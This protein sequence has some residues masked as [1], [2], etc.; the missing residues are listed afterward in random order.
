MAKA[1]INKHI[2][3]A[4]DVVLTDLF[5]KDET[6]NKGELVICNDPENPTI[7]IM[8]TTGNPRKIAG[9]SGSG[10]GEAY[11]DTAI[12]NAVNK[13]T[14][15]IADLKENP[16]GDIDEV[17]ETLTKDIEGIN[18]TVKTLDGTVTGITET[19]EGISG[20][21]ETITETVNG[22]TENLS[23]VSASIGDVPE[24]STLVEMVNGVQGAT[25]ANAQAIEDAKTTI[26]N[27]ESALTEEIESL[28]LVDS[29]N[30]EDL[31]S[32]IISVGNRLNSTI[33]SIGTVAEGAT[34][35]GMINDVQGAT[36]ANAQAIADNK[37]VIDEYTV[38]GKKISENP[39]LNTD[40]ILVADN[41]STLVK[42][43]DNVYPGDIIT[44]A[45]GKIEV[46]LA[47]T[48]LALTAAINDLEMRIGKPSEY[49]EETGD[50][51]SEATGLYKKYEE[52]EGKVNYTSLK[53]G[54][55]WTE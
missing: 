38:N 47:N 16:S 55:S 12:W 53:E 14:E 19:V 27:V 24:G 8:D 45:I 48:T 49:D 26:S 20:T 4:Q 40:D 3:S 42:P 17:V 22:V 21:I 29:Q 52:I 1:I 30:K 46:M 10:S 18:E 11:D 54:A 6:N 50:V 23:T 25:E 31:N 44:T 33:E 15:A 41:Y 39:V 51:I 2:D 9:G 32:T 13:N 5:I 36:E 28:K 34:V 7:Y 37:T 43:A 35:V